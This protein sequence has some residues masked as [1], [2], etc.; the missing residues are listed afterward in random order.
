MYKCKICDREFDSKQKLGGHSSSH[1]RG[2]QYKKSRQINGISEKRRNRIKL[3]DARDCKFCGKIFTP[4]SIGGHISRCKSNPNYDTTI[5]NTS[6]SKRGSQLTSEQKKSISES[7]KKAH[8]EGRA[9]N[10]GKS[11]W[12][13]E[14][15]YPEKF[16]E[17]V[18]INEFINK[19]YESEY[20][21]GI[22][23]LD[24]AWVELKKA[25]EIDGEQHDRFDEYKQRDIKKD[26]LCSDNGWEVLRIK[27]KDLFNNT[28]FEIERAKQFIHN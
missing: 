18:I 1:N 10:I 15:S 13:N 7:M 24:F 21:I 8:R 22:Y 2:E 3:G 5:T 11:R 17:K 4:K 28:K 9:W 12:N 16:F 26:K 27:W 19:N 6:Q 25:I 20:P 14:K 23:S